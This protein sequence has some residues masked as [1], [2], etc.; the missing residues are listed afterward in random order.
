LGRPN[1]AGSAKLREKEREREEEREKEKEI[2]REK[3]KEKEP[4]EL[5]ETGFTGVHATFAYNEDRYY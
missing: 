2:Q 5:L 3:D 1:L 4:S